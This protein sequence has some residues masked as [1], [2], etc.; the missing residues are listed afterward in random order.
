[1]DIQ[2]Q[3]RYPG[4]EAAFLRHHAAL[5]QMF[6]NPILRE[7]PDRPHFLVL[8]RSQHTW[9]EFLALMIAWFW[10]KCGPSGGFPMARLGNVV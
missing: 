4:S 9:T 2:D 7:P 5:D 3:T 10:Q 1:M 6:S 8:S